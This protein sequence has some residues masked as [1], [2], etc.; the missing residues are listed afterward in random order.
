[1]D[2]PRLYY[3]WNKTIDFYQEW[4]LIARFRRRRSVGNGKAFLLHLA[5]CSNP[6]DQYFFTFCDQDFIFNSS[7]VF[8]REEQTMKDFD[9][10]ACYD[11]KKEND[12]SLPSPTKS[13]LLIMQ[14]TVERICKAKVHACEYLDNKKINL[15]Y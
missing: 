5:S 4:S 9:F 7:N 1:M 13:S 14:K 3:K 10:C 11:G 12:R 15:C 6:T 2:K 8:V